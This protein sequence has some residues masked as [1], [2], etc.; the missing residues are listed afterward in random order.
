[1][2]ADP[3]E[4]TENKAANKTEKKTGVQ[5]TAS[6]VNDELTLGYNQDFEAQ[7]WRIE[8]GLWITL[9]IFVVVGLTGLLGKGPLAHRSTGTQD[10]ALTVNFEW[11]ARYKTPEIM[12][13]RVAPSLYSGGKAHLWLN[14]AIVEQMGLQRIIPEPVESRPGPNGIGYV[15][16]VEDATKPTLILFAK[17][18]S[19]PGTFMEEVKVDAQHDL[20]MRSIT[21]P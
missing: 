19:K 16:N 15:F 10:G 14:R 4:K 13:V 1:M 20:F 5:P 8:V 9:S 17:E 2:S 18:A 3:I 7:W 12:E 21:F 11:I 6:R